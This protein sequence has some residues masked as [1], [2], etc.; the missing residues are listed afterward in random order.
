MSLEATSGNAC[1]SIRGSGFLC[2]L[3]EMLGG[4]FG[5]KLLFRVEPGVLARLSLTAWLVVKTVVLRGFS[6]RVFTTL[7]PVVS[8]EWSRV[9][10]VSSSMVVL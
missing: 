7:F 8:L 1:A 2:S 6:L 4:L 10:L 9:S 5:S 3:V